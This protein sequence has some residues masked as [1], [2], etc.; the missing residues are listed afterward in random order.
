LISRALGAAGGGQIPVLS[1]DER[2]LTASEKVYH[3]DLRLPEGQRVAGVGERAYVRFNH[4]AEPLGS[5]WWRS[6]RQL[7]LSRLSF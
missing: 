1:S 3:V 6:G 5:Q 4:G 2:G 7:I